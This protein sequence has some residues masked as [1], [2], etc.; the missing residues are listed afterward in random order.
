MAKVVVSVRM[1]E[2]VRDQFQ[3]WAKEDR[4]SLGNYLESL[5]MHE[6]E[7]RKNGDVTLGS[8]DVKLD[9]LLAMS[10]RV[11]VKPVKKVVDGNGK[12]LTA[13]D[14]EFDDF[15]DEVSW[16]KWVDHLHK[17]EVHLNHYQGKGQYE[18][19]RE[20]DD[21]GINCESLIIELIKRT[22]KSIYIPNEWK[23]DL[24]KC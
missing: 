12:R 13:Y 11:K 3:E 6:C 23:R 7:R 9:R 14:M 18:R 8:L 22:A 5:F 19:F 1:E 16:R 24:E 20:L 2:E 17:S 10:D 21:I 15:L 4:R